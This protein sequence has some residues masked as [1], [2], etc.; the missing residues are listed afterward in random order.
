MF[1]DCGRTYK[2]GRIAERAE[3]RLTAVR[4]PSKQVEAQ[5]RW[6]SARD[7]SRISRERREHSFVSVVLNDQFWEE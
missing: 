4:R 3:S 2:S 7:H 5:L 6:T 1:W